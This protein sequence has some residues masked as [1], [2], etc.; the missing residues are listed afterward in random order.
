VLFRLRSENFAHSL[1]GARRQ[2]AP[3]TRKLSLRTVP[4]ALLF[5]RISLFAAAVPY[6]MRLKLARVAA[7]LEPGTEARP[8]DLEH[9]RRIVAYVERAIACGAPLVRPGCLTRGLTRYYFLRRAGLDVALVFGMGRVP[10]ETGIVGHCWL[11]RDGEPF[12]ETRDPRPFYTEM[13]KI[14]LGSKRKSM[15]HEAI[16]ADRLTNS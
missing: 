5:L 14:F 16:V 6:L 8:V 4:H 2:I 7:I 3:M 11:V 1:R 15:Q 9:E 13:H 12:L 10:E